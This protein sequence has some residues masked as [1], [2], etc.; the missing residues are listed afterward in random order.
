MIKKVIKKI[1]PNSL[2]K[3]IHR[4]MFNKV[5][6]ELRNTEVSYKLYIEDKGKLEGKV[7]LITGA[8]G[9][10]GSSISFRLSMQGAI[11]IACG[12]NIDNLKIVEKQVKNNGGNI[13]LY[14]L[15]V[16]DEKN[17]DEVCDSVVQKFGK[18]DILIN[19][20]GGSARDKK[21]FNYLQDVKTMKEVLDVNLIG[22]MICTRKVEPIM[23]KQK[24]GKIINMGSVIGI[25]GLAQFTDYAAAKAGIIGFTRSLAIE[26]AE[27]GITVNC[28][29][30]RS[31]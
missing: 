13:Y 18:I 21:N 9:A 19:N 22:T 27:Y 14:K 25:N 7:V 6:S 23:I 30:P 1:V 20:A 4:Y 10:I 17:I 3:K 16:T 26:L 2:K 29:S 28:I 8:S 11:V 24:S 5:K 12:R 31:S 15:D